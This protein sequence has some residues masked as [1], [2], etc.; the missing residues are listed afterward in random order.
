MWNKIGTLLLYILPHNNQH[1][2]VGKKG[3]REKVFFMIHPLTLAQGVEVAT[4]PMMVAKKHQCHLIVLLTNDWFLNAVDQLNV[5][6][7]CR[8]VVPK[9]HSSEH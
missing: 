5:T 2:F 8:F 1:C 6:K 4:P 9:T 3:F 7:K